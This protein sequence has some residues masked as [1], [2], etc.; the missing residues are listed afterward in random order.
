MP[1]H[2]TVSWCSIFDS[3]QSLHLLWREPRPAS[4]STGRKPRKST[5]RFEVYG[6]SKLAQAL[7]RTV[8]EFWNRPRTLLHPG[9]ETMTRKSLVWFRRQLGDRFKIHRPVYRYLTCRG[10]TS[11]PSSKGC[12]A[13]HAAYTGTLHPQAPAQCRRQRSHQFFRRICNG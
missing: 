13:Q 5:N 8:Y 1:E 2:W 6:F 4:R 3:V 9:L 11:G 12:S 10:Q 7:L